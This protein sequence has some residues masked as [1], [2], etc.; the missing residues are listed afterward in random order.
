MEKILI[1]SADDSSSYK[2]HEAL[3]SNDAKMIE[4]AKIFLDSTSPET[5][6]IILAKSGRERD[7]HDRLIKIGRSIVSTRRLG[8]RDPDF[9]EEKVDATLDLTLH[10]AESLAEQLNSIP[11]KE[12]KP[13]TTKLVPKV[14]F[15]KTELQMPILTLGC[16][17]FQQS[18]NHGDGPAIRTIDQVQDECQENLVAIMKHAIANG[19][20]H[21]ETAAAY[22]CSEIQIGE[23]LQVLFKE[24]FCTRDELILQTKGGINASMTREQLRAKFMSQL[25]RLKVEYV[26]L[27]SIHGKVHK[28]TQLY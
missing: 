25:E 14:R 18:W 19:C 28:D 8:E 1:E 23:T 17:R 20:N 3:L 22:G 2:D 24:G 15:G 6:K 7:A 4:L 27:F 16:M 11:E 13:R 10:E 26:D 5:L 12:S 21:I 9:D